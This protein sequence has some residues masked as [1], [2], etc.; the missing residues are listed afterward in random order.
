M[1]LTFQ[2]TLV[3]YDESYDKV[4]TNYIER[5]L[6]NYFQKRGNYTEKEILI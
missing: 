3:A 4:Q 6:R 5:T 1:Q 2:Y